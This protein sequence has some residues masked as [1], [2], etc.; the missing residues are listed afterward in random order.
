M[1]FSSISLTIYPSF[2]LPSSL[3][4]PTA[5]HSHCELTVATTH[6][7]QIP[8]AQTRQTWTHPPP[9]LDTN[10]VTLDSYP[11]CK[12][13]SPSPVFP[14]LEIVKALDSVLTGAE[15]SYACSE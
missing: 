4:S 15:L 11:R 14:S 3:P 2:C 8:E 9:A 7:P 12:L 6:G 10:S 13:W 5:V 1:L